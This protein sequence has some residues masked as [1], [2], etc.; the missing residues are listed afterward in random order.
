[1]SSFAGRR[2]CREERKKIYVNAKFGFAGAASKWSMEIHTIATI[3]ISLLLDFEL[4]HSYRI[5]KQ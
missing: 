4:L 1:M 3:Y 5:I 2:I